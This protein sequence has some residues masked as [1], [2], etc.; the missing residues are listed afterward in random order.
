MYSK[1][2]NPQSNL[3]AIYLTNDL[4]QSLKHCSAVLS[5]SSSDQIRFNVQVSFV[6]L[7]ICMMDLSSQFFE[8]A[9]L[10]AYIAKT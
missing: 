7:P 5:V 4:T 8:R 2:I 3:S 1:T 10:L 9:Q 6:V